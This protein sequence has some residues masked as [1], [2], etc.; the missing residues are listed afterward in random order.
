MDPV[1]AKTKARIIVWP[2]SFC[3]E[4]LWRMKTSNATTWASRATPRCDVA[5]VIL[6]GGRGVRLSGARK[7][8]LRI[9][10]ER[11]I[12]RLLRVL[13][14]FFADV[15]IAAREPEVYEPFGAPVLPDAFPE[16]SSLN[17]LHT[18]LVATQTPYVFVVA[19]DIPFLRPDVVELLLR[20]LSPGVDVA[21]PRWRNGYYEPLCAV[22]SKRCL[23][24]IAERL[25]RSEHRITAFF[26]D[27]SVATVGEEEL[28]AVDPGLRSFVNIN[29]PEELRAAVLQER[30]AQRE[31]VF[32]TPDPGPGSVLSV[33]ADGL[34]P[35]S[36][37]R[38]VE[39]SCP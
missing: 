14:M 5:G 38:E 39:S 31:G 2:F 37:S 8:L 27:V 16:R 24:L 12:E 10:G 20:K 32:H 36:I 19:C 26:P 35:E 25:R 15:A 1:C 33:L 23:P 6:A 29:T 9:G 13:G 18:A 28:R 4:N 7:G 30:S 3:S 21:A 22:Y 34:P 17:G 11:V